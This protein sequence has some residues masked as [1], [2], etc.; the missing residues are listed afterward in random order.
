L[1]SR[2]RRGGAKQTKTGEA[3]ADESVKTKHADG[4]VGE[5]APMDDGGDRGKEGSKKAAGKEDRR[6]GRRTSAGRAAL[7][8]ESA[9]AAAAAGEAAEAP[10]VADLKLGMRAVA[11]VSFGV[12]F[13]FPICGVVVRAV[14]RLGGR[15]FRAF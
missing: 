12:A 2:V 8:G 1:T 15:Q 11:A 6:G 10:Q 13:G 5:D 7:A 4:E 14:R 9:A 3:A